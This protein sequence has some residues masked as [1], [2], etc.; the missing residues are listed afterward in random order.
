[1]NDKLIVTI[2]R[3]TQGDAD[4]MQIMSLDQFSTNIVLIAKVIVVD[5]ARLTAAK[6]IGKDQHERRKG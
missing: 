2:S 4:Y 1:V 5:D 3:T 6:G